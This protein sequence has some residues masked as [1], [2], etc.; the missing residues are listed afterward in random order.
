MRLR[1][2][3]ALALLAY[4]GCTSVSLAQCSVDLT[5][6][7]PTMYEN[8]DALDPSTD[9]S[10]FGIYVDGARFDTASGGTTT[11]YTVTGLAADGATHEFYATSIAADSGVESVMSNIDTKTCADMRRPEPPS[12]FL[13]QLVAWLQ[14]L[15]SRIFA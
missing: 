3:L 8:G 5:W 13:A 12:N 6:T 9:L 14:D 1:I 2:A 11:A 15:W 7:P 10:G 4:L